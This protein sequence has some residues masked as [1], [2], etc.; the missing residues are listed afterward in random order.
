MLTGSE[1]QMGTFDLLVLKQLAQKH[2]LI[3]P[4][5]QFAI[6]QLERF[7]EVDADLLEVHGLDLSFDD[8]PP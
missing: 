2:S 5:D 1:K 7:L 8:R 3:S 4:I 6:I